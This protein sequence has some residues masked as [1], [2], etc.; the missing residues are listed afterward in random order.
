M[1]HKITVKYRFTRA[2]NSVVGFQSSNRASTDA[3]TALHRWKAGATGRDFRKLADED[4]YI[5]VEVSCHANDTHA[6]VQLEIAS[7][8]VG[9]ERNVLT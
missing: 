2:E 4:E 5:D 3:L 7:D 1:T 9:V 6:G 8:N